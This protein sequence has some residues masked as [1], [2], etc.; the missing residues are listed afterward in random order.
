LIGQ[1]AYTAKNLIISAHSLQGISII[2][3]KK[4]NWKISSC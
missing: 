2:V 4:G 1:T 3:G